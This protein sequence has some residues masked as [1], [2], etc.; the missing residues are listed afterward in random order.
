MPS[1]AGPEDAGD[2]EPGAR[3]D[4]ES[5]RLDVQQAV[6][7]LHDLPLAGAREWPARRRKVVDDECDVEAEL[8]VRRFD[9]ELDVRVGE[10]AT[11]AEDGTGARERGGG[12]GVP[13]C[14]CR[15]C[16]TSSTSGVAELV[17]MTIS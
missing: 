14:C 7:D 16:S 4:R 12:G 6:S 13:G 1:G 2:T 5:R 3:A 9:R 11:V 17:G 8:T 15:Y 10:R